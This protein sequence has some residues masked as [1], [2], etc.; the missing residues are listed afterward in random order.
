MSV[1]L[2]Q[3]SWTNITGLCLEWLFCKHG[4]DASCTQEPKVLTG[5][6]INYEVHLV[7][8]TEMERD[9]II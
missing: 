6:L 1:L 8:E 4:R 3:K 2:A 7:K 5:R 9:G